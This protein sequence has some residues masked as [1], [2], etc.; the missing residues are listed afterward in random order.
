MET[1]KATPKKAQKDGN[2]TLPSRPET[3]GCKQAKNSQGGKKDG[4]PTTANRP[5]TGLQKI[6]TDE[7]PAKMARIDGNPPE[8]WRSGVHVQG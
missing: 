1:D 2:P 4:N 6:E 7:K 8:V 3:D 5:R